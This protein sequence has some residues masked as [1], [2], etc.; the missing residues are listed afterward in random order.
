MPAAALVE[1]LPRLAEMA[2]AGRPIAARVAIFPKSP[3]LVFPFFRFAPGIAPGVWWCLFVVLIFVLI[4]E[5]GFKFFEIQNF[6]PIR[7]CLKCRQHFLR[8]ATIKISGTVSSFNETDLAR[9]D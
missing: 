2:L 6:L 1:V 4:F 8:G 5:N 3:I 7:C 9:R